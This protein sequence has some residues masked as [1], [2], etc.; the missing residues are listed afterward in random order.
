MLSN[1]TFHTWFRIAKPVRRK[2]GIS[3]NC[4]LVLNAGYLLYIINNKSFTRGKLRIF[5]RYWS[6]PKI[7]SYIKV[8]IDKGYFVSVSSVNSHPYYSLS[9]IGLQIIKELNESYTNVLYKFCSDY[10]IIL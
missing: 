8:L 7:D 2:Y 6:Q 1:I 3:T 10:S 4:I 5:A 9:E